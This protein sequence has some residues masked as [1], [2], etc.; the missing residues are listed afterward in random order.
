LSF[1]FLRCAQNDLAGLH[2]YLLL[3][4]TVIESL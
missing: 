1:Q 3:S 4:Q 2:A